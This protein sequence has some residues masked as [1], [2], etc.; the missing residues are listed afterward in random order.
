[1]DSRNFILKGNFAYSES[2]Q[3]IAARENAY[4]V[5]TDG[6]SQGIYAE[7]PAEYRDFPVTDMGDRIAIPGLIDL[8]IHASQYSYRGTKMDLELLDWLNQ[9]AFPEEAKFKDL[10]YAK[11]A[12]SIFA[13]NMK[14]SAT[15]RACIFATVHEE[16]TELLMNLMEETGLKTMIGKVN[17]DRNSPDYLEEASADASA[18]ATVRWLEKTIHKYR[19]VRPILTPR[20]IP[21]CSDELMNRLG[22]IRHTFG[23]PVQSHLSENQGEISLVEELCPEADFYGD[24]YDRCGMFGGESG[25]IMAHCVWSSREELQRMKRQGVFVA[26][27]PQSNANLASGIAPVRRYLDEG[28]SVGLGSDVAG[29]STESIFRAMVDAIQASKLRW[30]LVDPSLKPL[31]LE[32]AFYLATRGG[33][34]FFGSVG[35]FE[36]GY[37]LDVI[38]LDDQNLK[39]PQPLGVRDRLER[40]VYLGDERNVWKKYVAGSEIF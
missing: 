18:E 7:I 2:Q 31:K 28:L 23:I 22:T 8:H 15:T 4:L 40:I 24:A 36:R 39:H 9:N 10:D 14:H 19:N 3:G 34:A 11:K 16:A 13:E 38:V 30:R 32:E 20:F 6:I 1:M 25:T 33:G 35:S 12:Y 26:H 27:C 5:C 21:S 37:E 17:M 29:G